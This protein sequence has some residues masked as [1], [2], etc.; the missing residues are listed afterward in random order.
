MGTRGRDRG[1]ADLLEGLW[2]GL[3]SGS[4]EIPATSL[5]EALMRLVGAEVCVWHEF[6]YRQNTVRVHLRPE[7]SDGSRLEDLT[8]KYD[9]KHPLLRHYVYASE[10]AVLTP[11]DVDA[12]WSRH[13]IRDLV[14]R[15]MGITEQ[16]VIPVSNRDGVLST[17]GLGR[18]GGKGFTHRDRRAAVLAQH[19]LVRA[20]RLMSRL[21]AIG[22]PATGRIEKTIDVDGAGE[23]HLTP[24]E[25][26]VVQLLSTGISREAA[27]RKLG[28][29]KRTVDR[30][31]ENVNA[32]CGGGSF[33]GS[34][35][36]LGFVVSPE[37][38]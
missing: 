13:R 22:S 6:A 3:E 1:M 29:A 15:E 35:H 28:I 19:A 4:R 36:H 25:F 8:L 33:L 16:L 30:H 37:T 2:D 21:T 12:N 7:S 32:K 24:Q 20:D 18:Q 23:T 9:L 38:G 11:E 17:F 5:C 10:L 34:L 31:V 27:A 14:R 26:R